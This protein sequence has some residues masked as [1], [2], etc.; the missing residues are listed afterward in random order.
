MKEIETDYLI[1]GTGC[2]GMAF[3][4]TLVDECDDDTVMIDGHGAPGG[5]WNDA[6]PF[7]TPSAVLFYGVASASSANRIDNRGLNA[8]LGELA[9]GL[10][11]SSTSRR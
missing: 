11:F 5:H 9:S 10:R 2:V 7:V 1:I 3:A 4:D 8:G 6:Y